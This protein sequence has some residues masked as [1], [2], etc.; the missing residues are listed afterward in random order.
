VVRV[1]RE[2]GGR[3]EVQVLD[4]E[5]VANRTGLESCV[6]R[7]EAFNEALTEVCMGQVL[8]RE[9]TYIPGCRRCPKCG[10]QHVRVRYASTSR[11]CVVGDLGTYQSLLYG[12][13]EI[14]GLTTG[15]WSVSGGQTSPSR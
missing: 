12:N 3:Y 15:V 11:S 2:T 7:R 1:R 6:V 9:S 5:G 10:R 8:S 4:G 13:R 14:C